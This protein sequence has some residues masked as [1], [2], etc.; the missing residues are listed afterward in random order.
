MRDTP[1]M[2]T[3]DALLAET[4]AG[5]IILSVHAQPGARTSAIVGRHGDALKVKVSAPA[6]QGKANAAIQALL[7]R[8]FDVPAA[9]VSLVSGA[10]G[11]AKRF[12]LTGVEPSAVRARLRELIGG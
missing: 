2:D 8:A 12:C 7:A 5:D 4:A 11:R 10:S 9:G 3:V 6:D 1:A